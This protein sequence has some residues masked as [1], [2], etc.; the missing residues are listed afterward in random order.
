MSFRSLN[1]STRTKYLT[2]VTSF[3]G[4]DYST[5]KFKVSE[6]HAIDILN[7][8]YKDNLIQKREGTTEIFKMEATH[9]IPLP[10][11]SMI[12]NR[13]IE[14]KTNTT[15]FNGLWTFIGEDKKLH[16]IAH[17]GKLLYEIKNIDT[18]LMT[19]EPIK[20]SNTP[21]N[22]GVYDYYYCYEFL[23]YKSSAFIGAN[24]FYFLG[25]NKF[26]CLRFLS[27]GSY[28][29]YPIENHEDTYIPTTTISITYADSLVPQRAG[30]D[31][32]NLMTMWRKN[33]LLS[34]SLKSEEAKS[35]TDYFD[36]TLDSPLICKNE[37][38]DMADFSMSIEERGTIE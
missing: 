22:D 25:G 37:T 5:Q 34:G 36:Y 26:M 23:D 14:Y 24:R 2:S 19:I 32:V 16:V 33:E 29:F 9:Y 27:D 12:Q 3:L 4:V 31:K 11:D 15:N 17:V 10:F 7:F 30:L 18:D 38:K 1:L 28:I 20:S 6:N 13:E 35:K 21:E 8:I